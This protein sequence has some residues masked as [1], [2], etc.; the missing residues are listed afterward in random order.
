MAAPLAE[1]LTATI[2][3]PFEML[4]GTVGLVLLIACANVTSLLLSRP[5][6][7]RQHRALLG[8][9]RIHRAQARRAARGDPARAQRNG[10]EDQR[11]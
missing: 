1:Q 4:L 5:A 2:R 9:Q 7:D 6:V 11:G 3:G 8:A 10:Q